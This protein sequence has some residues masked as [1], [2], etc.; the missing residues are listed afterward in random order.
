MPDFYRNLALRAPGIFLRSLVRTDTVFDILSKVFL[1]AFVGVSTP[2]TGTVVGW[3][4]A[5]T[6]TELTLNGVPLWWSVILLGIIFL[7]GLF[8][9]AKEDKD[10]VEEENKDLREKLRAYENNGEPKVVARIENGV[11]SPSKS[12]HRAR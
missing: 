10:K 1:A 3:W 8:V 6:G 4:N 12:G 9:H 11:R 2:I 5:L 7:H